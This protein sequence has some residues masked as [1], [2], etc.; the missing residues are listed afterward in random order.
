LNRQGA[1]DAKKE[2][3]SGVE[4]LNREGTRDARVEGVVAALKKLGEKFP[5]V[6]EVLR[7]FGLL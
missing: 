1:R 2:F 7:S 4:K 6:Q 3:A 5:E